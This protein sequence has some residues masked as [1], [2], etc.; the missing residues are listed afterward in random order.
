MYKT[1]VADFVNYYLLKKI[2]SGIISRS[3]CHTLVWR[4]Q[5]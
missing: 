1:Y 4:L 5:W 3:D 2:K